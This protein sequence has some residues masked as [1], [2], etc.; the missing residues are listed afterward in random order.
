MEFARLFDP[1][2]YARAHQ[3]KSPQDYVRI[4]LPISPLITVCILMSTAISK[5]QKI[6]FLLGIFDENDNRAFE[7][8]EFVEM[9]LALFCGMGAMFNMLNLKDAMPSKQ[10]MEA[11]AR[12]LFGRIIDFYRDKTGDCFLDESMP[13][14]VIEDW[15]WAKTAMP[16][17]HLS[18]SSFID[19]PR[20]GRK[21]TQNCLK[22][23]IGSFDSRIRRR[24][25]RR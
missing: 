19:T 17:M 11:L 8:E 22:M 13:F 10:R 25:F 18:P 15:L 12:R 5:K 2:G 16:S 7:E 9:L 4:K 6:R 20:L 1:Q 23:R 3:T 21:K 14:T 24:W